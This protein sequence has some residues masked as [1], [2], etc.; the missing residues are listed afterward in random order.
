MEFRI[1]VVIA[2]IRQIDG[3]RLYLMCGM[4]RGWTVGMGREIKT[5]KIFPLFQRKVSDLENEVEMGHRDRHRIGGIGDL[6]DEA[7]VLA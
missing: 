1:P 7:A 6:G 5:Q 2:E 4:D 3:M